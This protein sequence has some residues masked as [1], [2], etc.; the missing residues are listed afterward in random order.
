MQ[1]WK[2]ELNRNGVVESTVDVMA[3]AVGLP[4]N[5]ATG[6]ESTE[7]QKGAIVAAQSALIGA[8]TLIACMVLAHHPGSEEVCQGNQWRA[9]RAGVVEVWCCHTHYNIAF[10][11]VST[12][13][14]Q[15]TVTQ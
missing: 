8:A 4:P 9:A 1:V 2:E 7:A 6:A 5:E 13:R 3:L 11:D 12:Y 10:S 15:G 14:D